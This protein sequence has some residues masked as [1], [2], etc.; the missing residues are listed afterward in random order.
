MKRTKLSVLCGSAMLGG[1]VAMTTPAYAAN[2]TMMQLIEIMYKKGTISQ[3]EYSMLKGAAAAD[4]EKV[5]DMQAK[6][7]EKVK[8]LPTFSK[9]KLEIASSD[10]NFRFRV[11]GRVH[12][13]T[14]F[15]DSD[16]TD[17]G[18]SG[19]DFRRARLEME[20]VFM[21]DWRARL[22]Y[23]FP[24]NDISGLRDAF[25]QYRG[26]DGIDIT[27]G[28]QKE[29][30][31]LEQMTSSN[32]QVYM[33]RSIMNN[34]FS[35][36]RSPGIGISG[37][38]SNYTLAGGVYGSGLTYDV[39]SGNGEAEGWAVGGRGTF[40]PINTGDRLIHLGVAYNHRQ[41]DTDP[42]NAGVRFGSREIRP[43]GS[44]E[45]TRTPF[46]AGGALGGGSRDIVAGEIAGVYGPFSASGEY[47]HVSVDSDVFADADFNAY[48]IEGN[49]F[50]TGESRAYKGGAFSSVKP[51]KALGKGGYGAWQ[52]GVRYSGVDLNDGLVI[53]GGEKETLTVGLNWFPNNYLKF[54]ANYL[55]T[56]DVDRPGT[57]VDGTNPSAFALRA[58]AYW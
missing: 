51:N 17:V 27:A 5:E 30:L 20:S 56:I 13:D 41:F 10:G 48:Y 31:F 53:N 37:G 32:H 49:Y 57:P 55:Y 38:G 40:T 1:M 46:L 28:N 11:G 23:D 22:Q 45:L 42:G 29:P 2:D 35:P 9:D 52:I 43:L 58:Q 6:V 16:G 47:A 25:V 44:G 19:T 54:M 39:N 50:L 21:K 33:E 3:E 24:G 26:F 36:E 14:Y 7:D 4:K 34:T 8:D 15:V 18:R 12:F